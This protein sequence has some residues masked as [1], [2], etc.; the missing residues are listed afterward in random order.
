M[1]NELKHP[2][3]RSIIRGGVGGALWG[4]IPFLILMIIGC[5]LTAFELLVGIGPHV[6]WADGNVPPFGV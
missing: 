1:T 5:A 3:Q 4:L 2:I 6:E